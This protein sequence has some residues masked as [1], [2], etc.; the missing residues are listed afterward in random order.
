MLAVLYFLLLFLVVIT[1]VTTLI[2]TVTIVVITQ[3]QSSLI[4]LL[5]LLLNPASGRDFS[6]GL[7]YS[8]LQSYSHHDDYSHCSHN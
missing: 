4:E 3:L 8:Q 1:T 6:R 2:M 7:F 5:R